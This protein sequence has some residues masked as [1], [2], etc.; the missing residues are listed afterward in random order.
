VLADVAPDRRN[1]IR[2]AG[3]M[4]CRSDHPLRGRKA[5]PAP[6]GALSLLRES[7]SAASQFFVWIYVA[8]GVI[9]VLTVISG[10]VNWVIG[11]IKLQREYQPLHS[12]QNPGT[13]MG[14]PN[15]NA[16]ADQR[17]GPSLPG[18]IRPARRP[19]NGVAR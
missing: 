5:T 11:E 13:E 16:W 8:L 12:G 1:T 14:R 19:N 9:F 18:L 3:Q 15:Q 2:D 10:I 4:A 6:S 17:I 7:G